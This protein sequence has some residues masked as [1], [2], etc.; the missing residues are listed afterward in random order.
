MGL[1]PTM[2]TRVEWVGR[3]LRLT[4]SEGIALAADGKRERKGG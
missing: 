2:L 3:G 1:V 4:N